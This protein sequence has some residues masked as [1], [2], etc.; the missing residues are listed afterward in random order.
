MFPTR[1]LLERAR[2]ALADHRG[3]NE[4]TS[5]KA[6]GSRAHRV[7]SSEAFPQIVEGLN[8]VKGK[9]KRERGRKKR[10]FFTRERENETGSLGILTVDSFPEEQS[11]MRELAV[12]LNASDYFHQPLQLRFLAEF[13]ERGEA[14]VLVENSRSISLLLLHDRPK[15]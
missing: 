8:T 11:S 7:S 9:R 6:R 1:H 14:S 3:V 2:Q 13:L 5:V 10:W 4:S 12:F 15:I